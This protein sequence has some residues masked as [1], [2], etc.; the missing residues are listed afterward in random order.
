[1][2]RQGCRQLSR[3]AP[4]RLK[5]KSGKVKVRGS[6]KKCD[7]IS[8]ERVFFIRCRRHLKIG[9]TG[10]I[11]ASIPRCL[12]ARNIEIR[13][14]RLFLDIVFGVDAR[15]ESR[16]NVQRIRKIR[17]VFRRERRMIGS[18]IFRQFRDKWSFGLTG[19]YNDISKVSTGRLTEEASSR[20]RS[21]LH[22][23][24]SLR[25]FLLCSHSANRGGGPRHT[26][27]KNISD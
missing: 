3:G 11:E 9:I 8:K 5:L 19:H 22:S 7:E 12:S 21:R 10:E 26:L 17:G 24:F 1:M 4:T 20:F 13:A 15:R 18:F 6:R 23:F 14:G 27:E 2:G 16:N 25:G